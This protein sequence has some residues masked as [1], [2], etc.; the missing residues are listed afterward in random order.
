[1]LYVCVCARNISAQIIPLPFPNGIPTTYRAND[2]Y[3]SILTIASS[4]RS[5]VSLFRSDSHFMQTSLFAY[6]S[7]FLGTDVLVR[8]TGM[9]L[10]SV[11]FDDAKGT[12]SN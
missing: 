11:I 6:S 4:M 8:D 9:S 12:S 3:S 1:M 10:K 5:R 2:L 7:A